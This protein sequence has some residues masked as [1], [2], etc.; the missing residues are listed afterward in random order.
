MQKKTKLMRNNGDVIRTPITVNGQQLQTVN[1]FKYLGAIIS[2]EGSRPE[3]LAR[4]ALT[5]A[6]L[7]KLQ[8][9]WKDQNITVG[10]KL[11]LLKALILS[12]FLYACESWTLTAELQRKI[13]A[14]EMR[15][16]R[17]LLGI[18]YK[19]H[20]TN[21]E[22]RRRVSLH[23]K[24]YVDL[25]STVK[26]RKLKWYGHVTR[27]HGLSKTILQGTVAGSRRRGRQKKRWIDNIT[28]WT[29][30]SFAA[31]QTIAHDRVRWRTVVARSIMQC[32][33]DPGGLWER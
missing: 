20:I 9:V 5:T 17:R 14:I 29:G 23:M 7:A 32:P 10:S 1:K 31:T 18:S 8:P 24:K 11:R 28:E 22:V 30:L 2:D 21:E 19:D 16:L 12:I 13:Q 3:I 4:T 27:T 15:S 26:K 25:L 33:Y 6:A